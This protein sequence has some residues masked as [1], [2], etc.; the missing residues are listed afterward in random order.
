MRALGHRAAVPIFVLVALATAQI[1]TAP[2]VDSAPAP[3]RG[4]TLVYAMS[5]EASTLDPAERGG[6][7]A[8]A[9]KMLIY[10]G[11][12]HT[13]LSLILRF[14]PFPLPPDR[15]PQYEEAVR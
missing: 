4:G 5:A 10:N 6:N 3:R 1:L 14:P 7:I 15:P 13:S 11:L 2:S 12:V 9:A 8:E